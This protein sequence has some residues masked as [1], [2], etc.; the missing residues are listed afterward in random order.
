MVLNILAKNFSLSIFD[1]NE[2]TQSLT[3]PVTCV[4]P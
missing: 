1:Y 4:Y 3:V 2:L